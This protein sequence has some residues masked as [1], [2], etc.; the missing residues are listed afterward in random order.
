LGFRIGPHDGLVMRL[1]P[2]VGAPSGWPALQEDAS[3]G[4]RRTATLAQ[5]DGEVEVDVRTKRKLE[6]E[7]VV[8]AGGEQARVTPREDVLLF[9]LQSGELVGDRVDGGHS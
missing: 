8:I 6:R 3:R 2:K 1:E 4:L 9:G 5:T 7:P